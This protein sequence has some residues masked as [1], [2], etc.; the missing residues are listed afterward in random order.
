EGPI[1]GGSELKFYGSN[2][3]ESRST[4]NSKLVIL[5][6]KI[7]C[8][9]IERN[10]TFVRCQIVKTDSNYEHDAEI[11]FYA[12]D[13]IDI[14]KRKFMID[15]RIKLDKPFRFLSP[16]TCGIHPTYGPFAGG[17][18]ILLF[19]KYLNIGTNASLQLGDQPCKIVS[20]L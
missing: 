11:S 9:V 18:Q 15:G 4:P 14:A 3:G 17:T 1:Q 10:D 20:E 2:F 7:P 5:I 16:I 8:N 6:D 13:K 19:G 12:K